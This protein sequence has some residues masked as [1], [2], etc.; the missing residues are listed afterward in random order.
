[1]CMGPVNEKRR[2]YVMSFRMG[3][4]HS[5]NDPCNFQL[6]RRGSGATYRSSLFPNDVHST[7]SDHNPEWSDGAHNFRTPPD[8]SDN[9]TPWGTDDNRTV[10]VNL[11]HWRLGYVAVILTVLMLT[12]ECPGQTTTIPLLQIPLALCVV[13][14]L[15]LQHKRVVINHVEWFQLPVPFPCW[16][17]IQN[18]I[19]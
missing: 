16:E 15:A 10:W 11:I 12:L 13:S 4:T 6:H 9:R 18:T 19:M 8:T 1:M 7:Q 3:W 14:A 2:Y 17:M 5:Q